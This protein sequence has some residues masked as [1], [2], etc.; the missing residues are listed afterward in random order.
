MNSLTRIF[1]ALALGIALISFGGAVCAAEGATEKRYPLPGHG[2]LQLHVPA[3]WNDTVKQL[4]GAEP[5]T[6]DF[7]PAEGKPFIVTL[8]PL[9]QTRADQPLPDQTELRKQVEYSNNGMLPYAIEPDTNVRELG[10]TGNPGYYFSVTDNAPKPAGYK[11]MT[12]GRVRA[13][14]LLIV[15]TVLTNEGQESVVRDTLA[16]MRGVAHIKQ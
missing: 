8:L 13:G 12:Q 6:L 2:S 7:A 14:D 10:G 1:K 9:W 15:F 11:F 5:P 3:G 16:M 4:P